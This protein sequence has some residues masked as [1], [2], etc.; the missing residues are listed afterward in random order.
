MAREGRI[1]AYIREVVLEVLS[2]TFNKTS[3]NGRL[4]RLNR[5]P[6]KVLRNKKS[7]VH[8]RG[9]VTNPDTDK[10]LKENRNRA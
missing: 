8:N 3:S 9:R 1:E 7:G 2:E 4:I 5:K 10:R 6:H